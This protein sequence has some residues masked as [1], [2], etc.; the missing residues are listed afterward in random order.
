MVGEHG[1]KRVQYYSKFLDKCQRGF[2]HL[3]NI[4]GT[5]AAR[6][7][8]FARVAPQDA[9]LEDNWP[10]QDVVQGRLLKISLRR[11]E[12]GYAWQ[13]LRTSDS[14]GVV[15]VHGTQGNELKLEVRLVAGWLD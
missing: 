2:E 10:F 7:S 8:S 15:G 1:C 3:L 5:T 6:P 13:K 14:V 9:G 12:D 11:A 4:Y